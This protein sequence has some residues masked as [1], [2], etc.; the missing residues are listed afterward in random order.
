MAES[1][2]LMFMDSC[3]IA[4]ARTVKEADLYLGWGGVPKDLPAWTNNPPNI[5]LSIKR[6]PEEICRRKITIKK[7]VVEDPN[8][9]ISAGGK[10]W[11]ESSEP[12]RHLYLQVNHQASDAPDSTIYSI[13]VYIGTQLQDGLARTEFVNASTVT[14]SGYLLVAQYITPIVRNAATSENRNLIISF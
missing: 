2:K 9:N 4:I 13:G 8:G 11:R 14:E 3:N 5:D 12:T 1:T 7:Y 10:K 6:L